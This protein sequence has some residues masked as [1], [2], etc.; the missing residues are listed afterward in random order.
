MGPWRSSTYAFVSL[1]TRTA[2]VM[3]LLAV[4][5]AGGTGGILFSLSS[6][7]HEELLKDRQRLLAIQGAAAFLDDLDL[8]IE[9]LAHI[10]GMVP[11]EEHDAGDDAVRR[12]LNEAWQLTLFFLGGSV[13]L[14]DE[15]GRCRG[16]EP[17]TV[18]C[19]GQSYAA[20]RWFEAGKASSEPL[21][22]FE[23]RPEN[24]GMISLVVPVH[25]HGE[26]VAVV[27]GTIELGP[28]EL[29][30]ESVRGSGAVPRHLA[31]VGPSGAPLFVDGDPPVDSPPWLAAIRSLRRGEAQAVRLRVRGEDQLLAWT[32][33]G[34]TG[35]GLIY[36]WSWSALDPHGD[37]HMRSLIAATVVMA[38]IGMAAGVLL[39]RGITDPMLSLA[40][41]VRRAR[42]YVGRIDAGE[43]RDEV[44]E[45][46]RAFATLVDEL[47]ARETQL[48]RDRDRV[49]ELAETL[50]QRVKDRTRELEKTR[51]ALIDTERLAA[52][53][54]AGAA[55]SHELRNSL[56]TLSVGM[57][58]LGAEMPAEH[59]SSVKQQV[60]AEISRL[61]SLADLL[62]DFA[63]PRNLAVRPTTTGDLLAR[64]VA[65]V[66]DYASEHDVS[67]SIE[68]A[69]PD[70]VIE[71]EDSLLQSV[72]SNLIR[73]A[74]DA[75]DGLD[76]A[77][78]RVK[79]TAAM[80]GELWQVDVDDAGQGVADDMRSQ[81]FQPFVSGRR[82]GVGLGLAVAKRFVE[83]HGG[84]LELADSSL[85]GACLRVRLPRSTP[86]TLAVTSRAP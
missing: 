12:V 77:R 54:R 35:A 45:L 5:C 86:S 79:V 2:L 81:L 61:R 82:G 76:E 72:F 47:A 11:V 46:R 44:A 6:Q 60:H 74:V 59:R 48:R 56:N 22:L 38:L 73:N 23:T 26:L 71:V 43:G 67:L 20:S 85:G 15:Q 9:E 33:V 34:R 17:A 42:S 16:A 83:L 3:T 1:G 53:G 14:V 70:T 52:L 39:A 7:S 24:S 40:A 57:D 18:P 10:S 80:A 84:T 64:S 65:I 36:A 19:R 29:F 31:F 58:A 37:E 63:R 25:R 4:L 32:P 78:R 69:V 62:L 41:D 55:L 75:V 68:D 66:E 50:E 27:L 8:A 21:V 13:I 49:S 28:G 51:D 30:D